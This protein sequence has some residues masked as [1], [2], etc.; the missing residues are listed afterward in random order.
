MALVM[1][2]EKRTLNRGSCGSFQGFEIAPKVL[3]E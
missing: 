1:L 3:G 2:Q